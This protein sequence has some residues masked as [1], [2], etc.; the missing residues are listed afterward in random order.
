MLS[1]QWILMIKWLILLLFLIIIAIKEIREYRISNKILLLACYTR[2][3][4]FI[5]ELFTRKID[6]N[7]LYTKCI[8]VCIILFSGIII[9]IIT[10]NGIGFGDVKLFLVVAI[11]VDI[12]SIVDIIINSIFIMGIITILLLIM[13][14]KGRKD[15]VPF[16][17]SILL[18]VIVRGICCYI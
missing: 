3:I 9:N 5:I 1:N 13:R 15:I 18:A 12:E 2:V 4:I 17:P 16:A 6:F 10:H 8:A 11:Y 7:I 14:K